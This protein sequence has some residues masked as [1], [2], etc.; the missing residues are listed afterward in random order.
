MLDMSVGEFKRL[1]ADGVSLSS[2]PG[3]AFEYS[4]LGYSLL[5]QVVEAA[6]GEPYQ[7]F[8][9]K[10]IFEPLGMHDTVFEIDDVPC[11]RLAIG[12]RWQGGR[13]EREDMLHDGTFGAMVCGLIV[14]CLSITALNNKALL[15]REAS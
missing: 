10:N 11:G 12:Y 7:A 6:A 3:S 13:W 5:G 15:C 2:V 1:I 9:R 14:P 8:I 4:N